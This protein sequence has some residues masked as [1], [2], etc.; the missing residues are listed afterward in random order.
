MS[1]STD[2]D[3]MQ[4]DEPSTPRS[5]YNVQD[6]VVDVESVPQAESYQP[7]MPGSKFWIP[8]AKKKPVEGSEFDTIEQAFQF[9]KEYAREGGFEVRRGEGVK[10]PKKDTSKT[11]TS[12]SDIAEVVK[13]I[14]RRKRASQR[15]G[16]KAL[17]RLRKTPCGNKYVV[18]KF[19]EK[20]NHSL[21][22]ENDYKYLRAARKL[23]F[24]KQLLLRQ[25][26]E[27]NI[28][29]TR[30]WKVGPDL[31]D[32]DDFKQRLCDIV[33]TDKI[34]PAVFDHYDTAIDSQ[35]YIYGKNT[36]NSNYTTPEFKTHLV[37]EKEAAEFYTHTIFYDV[38]DEIF[39]S[40]MHC[41][42]LSVQENDYCS[43][44]LIRDTEADYRIKGTWVQAKYEVT[45]VPDP[46]SAKCTCLRWSKHAT[47]K[48]VDANKASPNS[49]NLVDSTVREIY[50]NV[51]E[52]LHHL[53][54]DIEKLHIYRDDQTALM[55]K[56][57]L[58]VPNPPKLNTNEAFARTL[59]VNE[60]A[61][62]T[63]FTPTVINNKGQVIRTRRKSNIEIAMELNDKPM[64]N[65]KACGKLA[66]HDSR[67]CP[68]KKNKGLQDED[69]DQYMEDSD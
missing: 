4:G 28:G 20:H 64:R 13:V 66:R 46:C 47:R 60:P 44:F 31:K 19:F 69:V 22:H 35:R 43:V 16:C 38:Q 8:E 36:H 55:E 67:N 37:I 58:D 49:T 40:L 41:C 68:T 14:K 1:N 53:V 17:L 59:G 45:Y 18:Y 48:S 57:K 3:S 65:C 52:S 10:Q 26:S 63:I 27:A 5:N 30:A 54:G 7:T 56:A 39:S 25:L 21:V 6:N 42:S 12:S 24:S 33:W 62:L 34:D 32:K 29:P 51:E 50:N 23:T 11:D 15:C 9:Y 2:N 61:E